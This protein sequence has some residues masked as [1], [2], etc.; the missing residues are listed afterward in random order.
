MNERLGECESPCRLLPLETATASARSDEVTDLV[1]RDE[2][3]DL[4]SDRRN[5]YLQAAFAPPVAVTDAD[6]DGPTAPGGSTDAVRRA[7]FVDMPV[8]GVR[9]H[10]AR[11]DPRAEVARRAC[12]HSPA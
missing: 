6:H 2:V 3:A 12:L 9:A 10:R 7:E 5:A 8:E 11:V 4:P 1:E